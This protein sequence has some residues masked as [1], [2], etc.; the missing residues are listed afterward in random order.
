M[1]LLQCTEHANDQENTASSYRHRAHELVAQAES[2]KTCRPDMVAMFATFLLTCDDASFRD[3]ARALELATGL[4]QDVPERADAWSLLALAHYRT[5][6]WPAADEALKTAIERSTDDGA[7]DFHHLL[8][9][10]VHWQSGRRDEARKSFAEF[11]RNNHLE[12]SNQGLATE[13]ASLIKET[14]R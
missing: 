6:N 2:C 13:A 14:G 1:L 8:G 4:V 12:G 9:S 10:M 11:Q 3:P 7:T 5:G